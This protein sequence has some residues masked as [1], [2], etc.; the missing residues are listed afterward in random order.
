MFSYGEVE[1]YTV[2]VSDVSNMSYT[3]S[4]VTQNT[5]PVGRGNTNQQ[6]IGLQV[7]TEGSDNA[8]TLNE[9]I[10]DTDGTTSTS[11]I[12]NAKIYY[13]GTNST[14]S[15]TGQFG[16]TVASPSGT[17]TVTGTQALSPGTNYFWLT[18]DIAGGATVGNNAD[19]FISSIK[20]NSISRTPTVTNPSGNRNIQNVYNLSATT[21][22]DATGVL[23]DDGGVD[24]DYSGNTD[25]E[26]T[27][28]PTSAS[29]VSVSF[30]AFYYDDQSSHQ[31]D[32]FIYIYDGTSSSGTLLGTYTGTTLPNNGDP[33][34]ASSGDLT[35]RQTSTASTNRSGFALTWSSETSSPMAYSSS[36]VV[37]VTDEAGVGFSDQEVVRIEVVTTGTGS[38][39]LSA[40]QF[41][42][43]TNGTASSNITNAKVYY[44][45]ASTVFSTST[46]F[47]TLG[48][49]PSG[50]FNITGSQ[51]LA[52]GKN[53]FWLAYDVSSSAANGGTLDAS[54][55]SVTIGSARTP[56]TTSPSGNRAIKVI[57]S[58]EGSFAPTS[59]DATLGSSSSKWIQNTSEAKYGSRS[60]SVARTNT[61]SNQDRY[62]ITPEVAVNAS[63][64]T[65]SF[66]ARKDASAGNNEGTLLIRV[67]DNKSSTSNFTTVTSFNV[68]NFTTEW[69]KQTVSLSDYNGTTKYIAFVHQYDG[70]NAGGVYVD[71]VIM[72]AES[73]DITASAVSLSNYT[74]TGNQNDV[75][76]LRF[77]L[78]VTTASVT[79]NSINVTEQLGA[80]GSTYTLSHVNDG[81]SNYTSVSGNTITI[82]QTYSTGTHTF[83]VYV[84]FSG[85]TKTE[86]YRFQVATLSDIS[87]TGGTITNTNFPLVSRDETYNYNYT[88][89]THSA[90]QFVV[91]PNTNVWLG[92]Y[93]FNTGTT[94]TLS[95]LVINNKLPSGESGVVSHSNIDSIK[96]YTSSNASTNPLSDVGATLVSSLPFNANGTTGGKATFSGL[97]I[98]TGTAVH[99]V[100]RLSS[101]VSG[102]NKVRAMIESTSDVT[103][104]EALTGPSSDPLANFTT[105]FTLPVNVVAFEATETVEE[106]LIVQ[107]KTASEENS[108]SLIIYRDGVEVGEVTLRGNPSS[109]DVYTFVDKTAEFG[110]EYTYSLKELT[111]D[112]QLLPVDKTTV[113][114]RALP[115]GFTIGNS[116]PNPANPSTTLKLVV[117]E[118]S[119]LNVHIY[120]ILG[121][122][123][124]KIRNEGLELGYHYKTWNGVNMHGAVVGTGIYFMRIDIKGL[125]SGKQLTNIQK[126]VVYK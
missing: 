80:T 21:V 38:P 114:V 27:I 120:N 34:I 37:Q 65:I 9:I 22:T 125:Q 55:S 25:I 69:T 103:F 46:S 28:S 112:G 94:K 126:I 50:D 15:A 68:N 98:S 49:S 124:Y 101:S 91:A 60:A 33:I 56:S 10:F 5:S 45:G 113:G 59:W 117:P 43:N 39:A 108:K 87:V 102:T 95:G 105:D 51:T 44:T 76:V 109:G 83:N 24:G 48:S 78:N 122:E 42:F 63:D 3:S 90:S 12:S 32:D 81:S 17:H 119:I 4:T 99:I 104:T 118:K 121:Q 66:W 115:L 71:G 36:D 54:V 11:D 29:Q 57:E 72:P 6:I 100:Y 30:S 18:Y 67:A 14:F 58:F 82:G 75:E 7:V 1:D 77:T 16:S 62:L 73:A 31:G 74:L 123:V 85:Y 96:I 79:I 93:T 2:E 19:G 41:N 86:N 8:L 107:I 89:S 97:S 111:L 110:K 61:G 23:Y 84:D 92:S 20:V 64:N 35:V 70:T 106:G 47:G 53:Y 116:Y 26:F 52:T 88:I 40:T 13:T